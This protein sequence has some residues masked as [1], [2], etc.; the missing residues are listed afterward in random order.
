MSPRSFLSRLLGLACARRPL[1]PH[2]LFAVVP[3]SASRCLPVCGSCSTVS[4][5]LAAAAPAQGMEHLQTSKPHTRSSWSANTV[6]VHG[7]LLAEKTAQITSAA[8]CSSPWACLVLTRTASTYRPSPTP[9]RRRP[10]AARRRRHRARTLPAAKPAAC[11]QGC[12]Q[13]AARAAPV[14][15]LLP[16]RR[17]LRPGRRPARPRPRGSAPRAAPAP[18]PAP[19][20]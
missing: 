13:P 10:S 7:N 12:R 14:R 16:V 2:L 15:A 1:P 5:I 6:W 4:T 11:C 19:V 8:T 18:R 9:S 20:R 17:L 3:H